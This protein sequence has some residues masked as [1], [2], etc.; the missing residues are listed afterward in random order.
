[1]VL[2]IDQGSFLINDGTSQQPSASDIERVVSQVAPAIDDAVLNLDELAI[3]GDATTPAYCPGAAFSFEPREF[4]L[5]GPAVSPDLRSLGL[6]ARIMGMPVSLSTEAVSPNSPSADAIT[7]VGGSILTAYFVSIESGDIAFA[8]LRTPGFD[9][10][11]LIE[12]IPTWRWPDAIR[13]TEVMIG[14]RPA[15]RFDTRDGPGIS[16]TTSFAIARADSLFL[17]EDVD[18]ETVSAVMSQVR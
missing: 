7:G 8:V 10:S 5:G 3:H 4:V 12:S 15:T 9:A 6:P 13:P 18:E 11:A 14:G 16:L 17:F 2:A 1:M